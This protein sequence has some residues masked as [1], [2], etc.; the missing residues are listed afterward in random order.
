MATTIQIL[1]ACIIAAT[2]SAYPAVGAYQANYQPE[3][4]A[5]ITAWD[6]G[7]DAR[8]TERRNPF[9]DTRKAERDAWNAARSY[10]NWSNQWK[11]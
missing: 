4:M 5:I 10:R 6:A 9:P 11:R 2:L 7:W 8:G 3:T 1:A